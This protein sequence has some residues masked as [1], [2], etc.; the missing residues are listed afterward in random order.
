M[1]IKDCL[2]PITT[3]KIKKHLIIPLSDN[4]IE[5]LKK[6]NGEFPPRVSHQKYNQH[7]KTICRLGEMTEKMKGGKRTSQS[8]KVDGTYEKWE[9]ISSHSCRRTFV[10]LY[11]TEFKDDPLIQNNTGHADTIMLDL[12]D[13][14]PLSVDNAL[15]LKKKMD[16]LHLHQQKERMN[17]Q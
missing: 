10:T 8:K 16:E 14:S 2:I 11:R 5:I 1:I 15:S 17:N 3:K 4:I 12:Y 7:I 6:R 9:L 13:S